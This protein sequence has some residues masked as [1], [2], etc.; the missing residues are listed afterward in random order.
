MKKEVNTGKGFEILAESIY[1]KLC[2]ARAYEKVE[3]D[4]KLPGHDGDR[5]IDVLV[6]TNTIGLEIKIAI[7]CKDY[8]CKI[9]V[10]TVDAFHSKLM[11]IDVNKGILISKKGFSSTSIAKAKRLNI[12]LFTAHEILSDEWGIDLN[13]PILI[14]EIKANGYKCN[15]TISLQKGDTIEKDQ[16]PIINNIDVINL[17]H[18]KYV[19]Q[20][21]AIKIKNGI[22]P[23]S[24]E[25][26]SPPFMLSLPNGDKREA[27][28]IQL[29]L[30]IR[31]RSF[32]ININELKGTQ[33]LNN[34]INEEYTIFMEIPDVETI[35]VNAK[36]I[37]EKDKYNFS[38]IGIQILVI[39]DLSPIISEVELKKL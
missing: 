10:G 2:A 12:S 32:L 37:G 31:V 8:N 6:T 17:I 9:S 5:Q 1:K 28:S 34:I 16:N 27:K 38:G 39:P 13:I 26:L 4:V 11:D 15:S 30:D 23:I 7:E 22:Q 33:V 36:R 24:L 19:N 20:Q 21:L 3:H 18:K 29:F 14:E 25:E 35:S